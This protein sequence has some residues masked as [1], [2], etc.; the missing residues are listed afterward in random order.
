MVTD[1]LTDALRA[2]LLTLGIDAPD[3]VHLERPAKREHGDW[4]TNIA[5]T[6]AKAA[7]RNP[8]ELAAD[9]VAALEADPAP[10][11]VKVEIAGPG[12]VNFHLDDGWLHDVLTQVV[13]EGTD[14]YARPDLGGG[15]KVMVE[16]VSANPTGPLH[17]GHARGAVYGDSLARLLERTGH[18]VSRE[19]YV[20][21]RGSQIQ[22]YAQSLVA[23]KNHEPVPEGGYQGAYLE[24]W[25]THLPDDVDPAEW[26]LTWA[27]EQQA[28]TL[29][30][31]GIVF[32]TW[33]SE[34][35]L[36]D[37]DEIE[38][39]LAEL[40]AKGVAY[41][42]DGAVWLRSTDYGDDKDRVI[43]KTDGDYTYLLPD[44]AYHRDK[45][46]RGF[47]LLINVWG[48]DHHGYVQRLKAAVASLGHDPDEL[49]IVITQL[50]NLLKDGQ[51]VRLSKRSGDLVTI[52]DVLDEIG[53][54]SAR[55]T[56]LLQS[57][58]SPQTVD[59]AVVASQAMENPVF[60]VQYAHARIQSIGRKIAE[61]GVE[62]LPLAEVDL[63]LLTHDR[64]LELLRSLSELPEVVVGA[65]LGRAPHQV[66]TWVRELAGRFHGFYH[67][68]YVVADSVDPALTQA[69]LWLVEAVRVGLAIGLDLL[70]ADAPDEM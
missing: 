43:V 26:G 12:F 55:I 65:T 30:R 50:V 22:L 19:F 49:E 42:Q 15:R 9:L 44:I 51:E 7:G 6:S 34:R 64:E 60:Y 31:L 13:T 48:A 63:G 61:L 58:D 4:S 47:E 21:D 67:D 53:T 16:F 68:C 59:L 8:R 46:A 2:A 57:M 37:H 1:A 3:T 52:D 25:A 38:S 14:G 28:A 29:A 23:R 20:N 56:F 10:H 40:K 27:R 39:T 33:F 70:G 24:E 17:A 54:D 45:F 36:A 66:T 5:L 35:S 32:D 69:R 62:R 18:E 11:V 41:E